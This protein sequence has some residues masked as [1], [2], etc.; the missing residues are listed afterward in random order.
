MNGHFDCLDDY[1]S[2]AWL[3]FESAGPPGN[4]FWRLAFLKTPSSEL[5]R[6]WVMISIVLF[7]YWETLHLEESL[8]NSLVYVF[9][10]FLFIFLEIS[11]RIFSI[12][13]WFW[14]YGFCQSLEAN[15]AS[16]HCSILVSLQS[17]QSCQCLYLCSMFM[18]WMNCVNRFYPAAHSSR[19]LWKVR[20]QGWCS[21]R[22]G[23]GGDQKGVCDLGSQVLKQDSQG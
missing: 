10:F 17:H 13:R 22:E 19:S 9:L 4:I 23:N 15:S 6:L 20:W 12:Y 8:R 3:M 14:D 1:L 5:P 2:L 11:I 16:S 21:C 7:L 18:M